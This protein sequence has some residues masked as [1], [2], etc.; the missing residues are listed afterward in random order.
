MAVLK[1]LA[2]IVVAV[3][4]SL[5]LVEF[6]L[7]A[8]FSYFGTQID[9]IMYVYS[10]EQILQENPSFIGLPFVGHGGSAQTPG[11]NSLGYRNHEIDIDKPDGIFR[12]AATGGSTTY[13]AGLL[14]DETWPAQLERILHE[15]YGNAQVEVI[16]VASTAYTS[17][18]SL[19][20]YAFRV[21]DLQ[22]DLLMVYHATNDAKAR[23]IPPQCYSG[24]SPLRGLYKGIWR[25]EGPQLPSSTIL[26]YLGIGRGWYPNPNELNTWIV[27]AEETVPGCERDPQMSDADLLAVNPPTYFGRNLRN[28]VHLARAND[29]EVMFSTWAY[30][31]PLVTPDYWE[32]AF[33]EMNTVTAEVAHSL[34]TPFYDL[35]ADLPDERDYWLS[36]GEHQSAAGTEAQAQ[37]YAAFLVENGVIP[38]LPLQSS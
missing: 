16:N 1:R 31:A 29:T 36:D 8:Y 12:I 37:R 9:R 28:L 22:P 33:D 15:D 4:G 6:G 10:P 13:G 35:M 19:S 18:N 2:L 26:R 30:Y 20:N 24:E 3:I 11:H 21:V 17:W 25:V 23:L 27:P 32:T 14:P 38:P 7:R 34:E 5:L